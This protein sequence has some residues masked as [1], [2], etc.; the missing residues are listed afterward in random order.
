MQQ[1]T[2]TR[3]NESGVTPHRPSLTS[4][5]P[6]L[7][8]VMPTG[9]ATWMIVVPLPA[10]FSKL[11][12]NTVAWA[13]KKQATVALSTAEAEY[14]AMAAAVTEAKWLR[15]LLTD[16]GIPSPHRA[17]RLLCDNQAAIRIASPESS[18]GHTR[19]KHID[20]RHH[21]VRELVQAGTVSVEW[22]P[23]SDQLADICTKAVQQMTFKTLHKKIM[24]GEE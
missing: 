3:A 5:L 18:T 2:T 16:I 14:M 15:T 9:Q 19:C 1:Y 12:G 4:P 21:F 13:S 10:A 23:S 24:T 17:I 11:A 22:V 20:V 7:H 8:S 6:S